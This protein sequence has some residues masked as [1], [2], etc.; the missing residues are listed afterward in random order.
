M[1]LLRVRACLSLAGLVVCYKPAVRRG[2]VVLPRLFAQCL[3][4]EGLSRSE[5]VSVSWDPHPRELVE[6]VV[7][8]SVFSRFRGPILGCQP[9]MAPAC[10]ALDLAVCPGS[11]VVL[12]VGPRPCRGLRWLC[13]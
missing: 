5:V 11:G 12:L 8:A 9:V 2:F 4:L 7:L 6:G 13:L 10:V 3:A 1:T